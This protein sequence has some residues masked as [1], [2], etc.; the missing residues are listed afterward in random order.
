MTVLL[1]YL[2]AEL[3]RGRPDLTTSACS[4]LTDVGQR[5]PRVFRGN[6]RDGGKRRTSMPTRRFAFWRQKKRHSMSMLK[7]RQ[8]TIVDYYVRP[9]MLSPSPAPRNAG[10]DRGDAAGRL[11]LRK[12]LAARSQVLDKS[13][14]FIARTI[15][16]RL[17][18]VSYDANA[19][20]DRRT[21]RRLPCGV[22]RAS[23][24]ARVTCAPRFLNRP[25]WK[26]RSGFHRGMNNPEIQIE[27]S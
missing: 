8:S 3:K 1:T 24:T 23:P 12:R 9:K 10:A 18:T 26:S 15:A 17:Y 27:T 14:E 5:K 22:I 6:D 20:R 21:G 4:R 2:Q 19:C 13:G 16:L 11:D 7:R 25:L